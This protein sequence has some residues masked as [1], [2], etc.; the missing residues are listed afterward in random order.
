[1]RARAKQPL[2]IGL[3]PS[4][5]AF[6]P[7]DESSTDDVEA[8]R[9]M[10]FAVTQTEQLRHHAWWLD[11]VYLGHYPEEGLKRY[12]SDA[13]R[14]SEGDLELI[15]QPLDVCAINFYH[16]KPVRADQ[17][18]KPEV[19]EYPVGY[20]RTTQAEWAITAPG[21]YYGLK[22]FHERYGLPMII[23]ENGH[24][25]HDFVMLDGRVHDPERIDYTRRHLLQ[26][27]RAISDGIPVNGY[28]HWTFMDN[29]EWAWGYKIRVG[30]VYTDYE[31]QER[32]PKDSAYWYRDVITT[33]GAHLK[34]A[35]YHYE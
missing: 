26:V 10:E 29:F 4:G 28:L 19:L 24:Q 33:N 5:E 25:N 22:F 18:G 11:P 16:A 27:E 32:T 8:A 34:K 30:L 35:A 1:M 9:T 2:T 23:T 15:N 20:P 7:A 17:D 31:T 13:P 6:F 14:I 12:G 21:L 3:V